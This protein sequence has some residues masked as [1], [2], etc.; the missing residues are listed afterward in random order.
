VTIENRNAAG[1][2]LDRSLEEG[3][4]DGAAVY[5]FA[6][7]GGATQQWRVVPRGGAFELRKLAD[8]RCLDIEVDDINIDA[9]LH[10]RTC[11]GGWNQARN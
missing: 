11:H 9:D 8:D 4:V 7:N 10:A 1:K 3:N 2:C 6:C 5:I